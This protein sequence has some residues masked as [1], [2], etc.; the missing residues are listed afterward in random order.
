MA[1]RDK[2]NALL[3]LQFDVPVA[4]ELGCGPNKRHADALGIDALDYPGVDIVGDIYEVLAQF[5]VGS[6]DRVYSYHFVEHVESVSRLLEELARVVKTGGLVEFIAPH[7]S[8]P[9][10]YS[11]P[12]HRNFFG[13]YTFSYFSTGS[14]LRRKVPTYQ[15]KL[16]FRLEHVDLKFKS[17]PPFYVRH[18]LKKLIG[19]IF[20]SCDYMKELYEENFCYLFPCYEVCYRLRRVE[21]PE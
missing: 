12:T 20:N 16:R 6:V 10:F 13:L 1:I 11:D 5:P 14:P 17:F 19:S 15:G 2:S 21:S 8:N 18:A 7:F 9:H 4:I 3:R